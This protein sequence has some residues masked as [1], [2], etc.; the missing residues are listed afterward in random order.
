[1]QSRRAGGARKVLKDRKQTAGGR[2]HK[3]VGRNHSITLKEDSH[4]AW[5]QRSQRLS[6]VLQAGDGNLPSV[7]GLS[8]RG[9]LFVNRSDSSLFT[10]CRRKYS[11]R[12]S[13][14]TLPKHVCQQ[15]YRLRR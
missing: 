10:E 7:K 3:A 14:A 2:R 8:T 1:M 12:V 11:R 15:T 6:D 5:T 9:D 13:K 4:A